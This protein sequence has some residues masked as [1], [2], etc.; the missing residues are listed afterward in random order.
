[1]LK[2]VIV[3]PIPRGKLN[4]PWDTA[5]QKMQYGFL[6]LEKISIEEELMYQIV[7]GQWAIFAQ[8]VYKKK[9]NNSYKIPRRNAYWDCESA[10]YV[11]LAVLNMCIE[12]HSIHPLGKNYSNA[13][14]WFDS[15]CSE[16]KAHHLKASLYSDYG[17]KA[18]IKK[19]REISESYQC[20][21]NPHDSDREIHLWRLIEAMKQI[22]ESGRFPNITK[23]I[24]GKLIKQLKRHTTFIEK[25]PLMVIGIDKGKFFVQKGKE[26]YVLSPCAVA[27]LAA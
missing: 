23:D 3:K 4:E 6:P 9:W 13:A 11:L 17:R 8:W 25:S 22:H 24:W 20:R 7:E 21:E 12:V 1:M 15:I 16:M 14:V 5:I 18:I 2:T 10:G 26:R 19:F 27:K